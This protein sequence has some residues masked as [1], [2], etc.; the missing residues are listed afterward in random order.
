MER[1]LEALGNID[2][3]RLVRD[4]RKDL[5]RQIYEE[6]ARSERRKTAAQPTKG[7]PLAGLAPW[8]EV[9]SPH[10][11]VPSGQFE[12][13]EFA[14]DLHEVASGTADHEYQ[15]PTAFFRA[16]SSPKGS[17]TYSSERLVA[18]Q[19]RAVIRSS[20]CRPTSVAARPTR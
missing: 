4:L 14:A 13:A 10:A 15:D 1:V 20:S 5:M 9:I 12:Q 2:E 3:R 18:C 19:V 16:H 11:D 6:E 17:P 8:R 7:Q